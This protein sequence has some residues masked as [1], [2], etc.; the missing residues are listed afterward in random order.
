MNI[1]EKL[2]QLR[3]DIPSNVKIVA[4]SK[5]RSVTEILEA[6]K[7]GQR[8]FGENKAQELAY[9]HPLLPSDIEWH[10]IGHLQTNKVKQILPFTSLVHSLDSLKLLRTINK[11]AQMINQTV[12][13][14]LQFH[15][16]TEETKYGLDLQEAITLLQT[17]R[18]EKIENVNIKGL[19]GMATNTCDQGLIRREFQELKNHF[20]R[21][22]RDYFPEDEEFKE[23]SIGMS[24]DYLLALQEGS[25]MIRVGTAIFGE[26]NN[27]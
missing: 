11:E 26:R 15:I 18:S 14:L 3:K 27:K 19:M 20:F 24:G 16:A 21:L 2:E 12:N 9:K 13:C 10:F 22:K 8:I 6:Y 17:M 5:T 25:T 23:L 4:V 1:A 7:A